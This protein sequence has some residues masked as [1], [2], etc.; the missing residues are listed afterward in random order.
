MS[1][2]K[3]LFETGAHISQWVNKFPNLFKDPSA[4]H[5]KIDKIF[6]KSNGIK[7]IVLA[8]TDKFFNDSIAWMD[9][10]LKEI[11]VVVL[12]DS[13]SKDSYQKNLSFSCCKLHRFSV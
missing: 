9:K 4:V 7:K 3:N 8:D 12:D 6:Y 2:K 13:L 11:D 1:D 10:T 5:E